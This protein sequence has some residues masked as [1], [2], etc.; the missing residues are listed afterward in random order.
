MR[1]LNFTVE[2]E[3]TFDQEFLQTGTFVVL[4]CDNNEIWRND[5]SQWLGDS[6]AVHI[7]EEEAARIACDAL[8]KLMA[9]V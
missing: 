5:G 3:E 1:V 9:S 4:K 2:I 8:K 7:Q 6:Y